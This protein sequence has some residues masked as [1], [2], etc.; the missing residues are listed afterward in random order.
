MQT[1]EDNQSQIASDLRYHNLG[2]SQTIT[3][4]SLDSQLNMLFGTVDYACYYIQSL[5]GLRV[6]IRKI[7]FQISNNSNYIMLDIL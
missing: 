7:I 1:H 4:T 6:S 5:S 2:T 3:L